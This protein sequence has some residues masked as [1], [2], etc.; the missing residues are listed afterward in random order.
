[1]NE[2]QDAEFIVDS[3]MT[4]VIGGGNDI[5]EDYTKK[6][7]ILEKWHDMMVEMYYDEMNCM[8]CDFEEAYQGIKND[9]EDNFRD[10]LVR[11]L[12]NEG[13]AK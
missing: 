4:P 5:F 7:I 11:A 6:I 3:L 13:I 1:M 2:L 8:S 10:N 9:I 12:I